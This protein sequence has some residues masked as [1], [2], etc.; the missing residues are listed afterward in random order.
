MIKTDQPTPKLRK[1]THT[2]APTVGDSTLVD[3][4]V[5]LVDD[6]TALVGGQTTIHSNMPLIA[7]TIKPKS[8]IRKH[9]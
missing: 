1:Q 9:Y 4:T 3:D 5:A 6:P 2:S 8:N 7:R